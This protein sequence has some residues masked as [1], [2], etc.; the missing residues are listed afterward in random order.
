MDRTA[1]AI[2][3][4]SLLLFVLLIVSGSYFHHT[5][6]GAA[7]LASGI[8]GCVVWLCFV[9]WLANAMNTDI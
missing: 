5:G 8:V 1:L 9:V 4:G 7:M 2:I 3:F 6:Y